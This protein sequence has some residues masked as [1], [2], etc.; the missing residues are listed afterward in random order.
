M[1]NIYAN[2][3]CI[4]MGVMFVGVLYLAPEEVAKLNRNDSKQIIWRMYALCYVAFI[5]PIM[6]YFFS[7]REERNVVALF[8]KLGAI[9]NI[10][11]F[12][13]DAAVVYLPIVLLRWMFTGIILPSFVTASLFLGPLLENYYSNVEF[14][15][16]PIFSIQKIYKQCTS[17]MVA[18]RAYIVAPIFEEWVFR[19]CMV[20]VLRENGMSIG[21]ITLYSPLYFGIAHL[22]H[23]YNMVYNEKRPWKS[24]LLICFIQFL[25]TSLFGSYAAYVFCKTSNIYGIII[26]HSFC[27][28]MGLPQPSWF[29]NQEHYLYKYS[30]VLCIGYIIGVLMFCYSLRFF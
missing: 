16:K 17:D 29:R 30:I 14:K 27:N 10:N 11:S 5:C 24:S 23:A 26:Q 7:N 28:Y 6:V 18:I 1:E 4:C 22:H 2:L 9:P 12:S 8:V 21:N 25:Y 13:G 19:A 20:V 3:I 15:C